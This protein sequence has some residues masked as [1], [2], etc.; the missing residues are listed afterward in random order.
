MSG[1]LRHVAAS[2]HGRYLVRP[3]RRGRP[4]LLG[5]HGYGESAERQ[6]AELVQIPELEGWTLAAVQALHP[7]YDRRSGEVVASWMTKQ[8]R[9]LAIAD[10]LAYVAAVSAAVRTEHGCG[11][12]AYLGFSQGT[13]MAYRAA[14]ATRPLLGLIALGGDVPPDVAAQRRP[15]LPEVLIGWGERDGWYT[16]EKLDRDVATLR[17]HGIEPRVVRLA[18]GHE[19][20]AEFRRETGAFLQAQEAAGRRT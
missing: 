12:L 11:G 16:A 5:F 14:A 7:F 18:A 20:T 6:F 2:V 1:E 15:H 8:D 19:W 17:G 10:N 3:G 4:A 9:E 13:A